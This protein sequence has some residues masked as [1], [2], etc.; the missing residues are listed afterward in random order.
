M[1]CTALGA[2]LPIGGLR[3]IGVMR[4]GREVA[5]VDVYA[6]LLEG[7]QDDD[8]RSGRGDVVDR[9]PLRAAGS[10]SREGEASDAL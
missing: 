1:R 2:L 9:A 7:R 4:E 10:T 3:D 5:R 8:V 6:Y